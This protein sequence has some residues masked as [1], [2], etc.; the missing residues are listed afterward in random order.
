MYNN[1]NDDYY[2]DIHIHMLTLKINVES[3]IYNTITE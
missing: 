1:N 3:K 2:V